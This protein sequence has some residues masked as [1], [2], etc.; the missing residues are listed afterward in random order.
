MVMSRWG[1]CSGVP[2]FNFPECFF[3]KERDL[4]LLSCASFVRE[5][6]GKEE[7]H[8]C[9]SFLSALMISLLHCFL[10]GDYQTLI[11][12]AFIFLHLGSHFYWPNNN[13]P[14]LSTS[15]VKSNPNFNA[16]FL[17]TFHVILTFEFDPHLHGVITAREKED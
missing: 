2:N 11:S 1:L 16:L 5:K 8:C 3:F 15:N 17:S 9:V 12:N 10:P 6:K 4:S 13:P 14:P 7:G